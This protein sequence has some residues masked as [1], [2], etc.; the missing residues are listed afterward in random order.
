MADSSVNVSVNVL[1]TTA[2]EVGTELGKTCKAIGEPGPSVG[3]QLFVL[4]V[5]ETR[6]DRLALGRADGA[7]LGDDGRID[8]RLG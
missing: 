1:K 2:N 8:N 6:E 4:V 3:A 5:A 7:A